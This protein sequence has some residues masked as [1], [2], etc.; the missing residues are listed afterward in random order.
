MLEVA[1]GTPRVKTA[2][3]GWPRNAAAILPSSRRLA[4]TIAVQLGRLADG[5][6]P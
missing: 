2:M 4:Q 5:P 3:P 6:P 1:E